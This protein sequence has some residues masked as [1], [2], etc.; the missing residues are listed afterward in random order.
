MIKIS[1]LVVSVATLF[2][3]I[4]IGFILR[5]VK[6]AEDAFAKNVS[7]MVIYVGQTAM[8]LHGFLIEFDATVFKNFCWAFVFVFL[9][10]A[11][12]Y[13]LV[14]G[15]FK[16]A[17]DKIRSVLRYGI[18]FSNAGFMGIPVIA[19]VF[20]NDY[21]IYATAYAACFN[22]FSFSLGRLIYTND[23]KYISVKKLFI[24]PGFIPVALGVILYATGIGGW[25][26]AQ[27]GQPGFVSQTTEVLYKVCGV[28]KELVA[29]AS[30]LVIGVRLA[31]IRFKGIFKDKYLYPFL[32]ARAFLC[33]MLV[34]LLLKPFH[35]LGVFNDAVLSTLIVLSATPAASATTM[36]AE[37]YGADSV[38]AGKLVALSTLAAIITMPV[39]ALLL[40]I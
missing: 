32:L 31:D 18:M 27:L 19:D 30:M 37:L 7:V 8:L 10:H 24:N 12:L 21:L 9:I 17:P 2:C 20:G 40:Y 36:F 38:Y 26:Q 25:I 22:I 4:A 33:P 35:L 15:L 14:R 23:K 11:M 13:V 3:Y 5:K 28:C 29:P 34:F 39:A 16:K 1:L 6:L